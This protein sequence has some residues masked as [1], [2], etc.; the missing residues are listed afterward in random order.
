MSRKIRIFAGNLL[1]LFFF[2]EY[3][4]TK[5]VN[6]DSFLLNVLPFFRIFR[7]LMCYQLTN[8]FV[9][10]IISSKLMYI[11]HEEKFESMNN[12]D[13]IRFLRIR[14]RKN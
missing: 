9:E 8:P 5:H 6:F 11:E 2:A 14:L 13:F 10:R 7:I 1:I 3:T 4:R 12:F